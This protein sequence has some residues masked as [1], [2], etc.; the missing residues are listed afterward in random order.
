MNIIK[1]ITTHRVDLITGKR[2][3][4]NYQSFLAI[5]LVEYRF[6]L[7][8]SMQG[9]VSLYDLNKLNT[10]TEGDS[11]NTSFIIILI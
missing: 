2:S 5:D 3:L 8:G 10:Y 6:L 11:L 1:C 4:N 7:S 9:Q